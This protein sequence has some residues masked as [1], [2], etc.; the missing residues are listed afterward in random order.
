M[1]DLY[2]L[3]NQEAFLLSGRIFSQVIR[4]AVAGYLL[5]T[6][7]ETIRDYYAIYKPVIK[8]LEKPRSLD[9]RFDF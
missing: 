9:D 5:L 4:G 1:T 3:V 7:C 2:F 6:L 8:P